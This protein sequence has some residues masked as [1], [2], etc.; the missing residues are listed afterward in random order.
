MS[1]DAIV[2]TI[3]VLELDNCFHQATLRDENGDPVPAASV[4]AIT[5]TLYN[6]TPDQVINSRDAVSVL[7]ANGGSLHATSGVFRMDFVSADNPIVDTA[8]E[9]F[10]YEPHYALF[11]ATWGTGKRHSWIVKLRVRQLH[12]VP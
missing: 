11:V 2:D 12:R 9:E 4:T 6:G 10:Q 8:V 7:N 3:D 5:L 1:A